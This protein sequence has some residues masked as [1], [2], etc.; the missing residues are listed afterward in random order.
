MANDVTTGIR[1]VRNLLGGRMPIEE[2]VVISNQSGSIF[3]GDPVK[4]VSD[5][6]FIVAAGGDTVIYGVC[7]GVKQYKTAAGV[8]QGGNYLPTGTTY[9]GAPNLENPQASIIRII[10]TRFQEFEMDM[11]TAAA[12]LT[13]AQDLVGNNCDVSVG[14]GSTTTGRS[15][16]VADNSSTG[17]GTANV[18]IREVVRTPKNDVTAANWKALV[19]FVEGNA[20]SPT[21]ATGV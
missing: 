21:S 19:E 4:R 10:P 5:G 16:C 1:W 7:A 17:T 14:T 11:N 2:G 20:A 9:T 13:A 6:T 15:A 18:R 12:T 3:T 8:V